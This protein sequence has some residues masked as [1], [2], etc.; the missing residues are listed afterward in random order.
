MRLYD[1]D[2]RYEASLAGTGTVSL[3]TDRPAQV[4][5]RPVQRDSLIWRPGEPIAL[6]T[7]PIDHAPLAHGG[8]LFTLR[9]PGVRDV[10]YPVWLPRQGHWDSGSAVPLYSAQQI[11]AGFVYVAP[12]PARIGGDMTSPEAWPG[13]QEWV[14]GFFAAEKHVTL[15]EYVA[16]MNTLDID[17]ARARAPRREEGVKRGSNYLDERQL[18]PRRVGLRRPRP[19]RRDA[20][21]VHGSD[22]RRRGHLQTRARRQLALLADAVPRALPLRLRR[23]QRLLDDRVPAR[24]QR[25]DVGRSGPTPPGRSG[26]PA[27]SSRH[28][29]PGR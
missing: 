3:R 12:G 9:A 28:P 6:G 18:H 19:G 20:G 7:T 23:N 25:S 17:E 21:V 8:W 5:A 22:L 29:R 16:F 15:A 14:G 26:A 10:T 2:G 24:A 11:G 1:T 27:R 13:G 4:S